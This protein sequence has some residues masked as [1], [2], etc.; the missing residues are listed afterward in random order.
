MSFRT[1]NGV[2]LATG[3][4]SLTSPLPATGTMRGW[5]TLQLRNVQITSKEMEIFF[6]LFHGRESGSVEWTVGAPRM[7][8]APS[9]F[10]FMPGF[11][12]SNIIA[13]ASPVGR[14]AWRGRWSYSIFAGS[15]EGG[16]FDV[17]RK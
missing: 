8:S 3:N 14:G 13:H 15:R 9:S 4:I 7:G 12:D 5:Y 6:Q 10:D 2:E 1:K 17:A 16:S 11:V